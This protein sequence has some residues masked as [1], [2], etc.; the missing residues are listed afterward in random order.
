MRFFSN[1]VLNYGHHVVMNESTRALVHFRHQLHPKIIHDVIVLYYLTGHNLLRKLGVNSRYPMNYSNHFSYWLEKY[2][3]L[4]HL[5]IG[6]DFVIKYYQFFV[7]KK[8]NAD[9]QLR[10][11]VY[12][13]Y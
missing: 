13:N 11:F 6:K 7:K 2:L 9:H 12:Q 8:R 1:L 4:S 5:A 10:V 3:S